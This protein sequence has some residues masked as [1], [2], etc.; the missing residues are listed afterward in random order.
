MCTE[1]FPDILSFRCVL[2]SETR[3]EAFVGVRDPWVHGLHVGD[4]EGLLVTFSPRPDDGT[5]APEDAGASVTC[6]PQERQCTPAA[7]TLEVLNHRFLQMFFAHFV[8]K[9]AQPL[10]VVRV[11][12]VPIS[13]TCQP[14]S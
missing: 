7:G 13:K 2:S 1:L 10:G 8:G 4:G 11:P 6:R 9:V 12:F 5:L 14:L 3:L